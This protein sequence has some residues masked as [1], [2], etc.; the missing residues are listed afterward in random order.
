MQP[1]SSAKLIQLHGLY[2]TDQSL[3]E[4]LD[5]LNTRLGLARQLYGP[6]RSIPEVVGGLF[7]KLDRLRQLYG[8]NQI[9]EQILDAIIDRKVRLN[10]L[11]ELQCKTATTIHEHEEI[12]TLLRQFGPHVRHLTAGEHE[13]ADAAVSATPRQCDEIEKG[14]AFAPPQ[15]VSSLVRVHGRKPAA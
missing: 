2:G 8:P 4:I 1:R 15:D 10:R 3:P 7:A 11:I 5:G 6:T 12:Q 9:I 14:P 13:D